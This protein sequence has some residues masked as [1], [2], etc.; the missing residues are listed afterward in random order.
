VTD[1]AGP[2]GRLLVI[3]EALVDIITDVDGHTVEHPGGSP[4]NVAYGLARLGHEVDLLTQLGDDARGRT[5]ADQLTGAG[6][7]VINGAR[8]G[9]RTATARAR[10]TADRAAQYSFDLSWDLADGLDVGHPTAVHTGSIG[11]VLRPGGDRV[12]GLL[13]RLRPSAVISYDPNIRPELMGARAEVGPVVR[14]LVALS[15]IVKVSDEDLQWLEPDQDPLAVAGQWQQLGPAL[16]V[17]T[18]GG[19]G[20]VALTGRARVDA[21]TW[22]G[23]VVDTVGAGDSF[24]AGLLD[25]LA[26]R[27]LLDARRRPELAALE[28]PALDTV[29]GSASA[30]AAV[31]V[32]R[33]GAALP[34]RAELDAQLGRGPRDRPGPG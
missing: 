13:T 9:A 12:A 22:A 33:A 3:G 7:R 31:T 34:D 6:V 8:P 10:L 26:R 14:A 18:R 5:V 17:V 1:P 25:A 21:P 29:V 2:D 4:A 15:D 23:E 27:H 24:M 11:A 28:A 20:A 32:G 16:V 30:A 19:A